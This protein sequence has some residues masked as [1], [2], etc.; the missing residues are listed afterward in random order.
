MNLPSSQIES[1]RRVGKLGARGVWALKYRGGLHVVAADGDAEPLGAGSHR[2]VAR[3]L[4]QQRH[5]DLEWT[6]LSKADHYPLS[7][8]EHLLPEATE[9]TDRLHRL[10]EED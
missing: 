1:K 5:P 3:H 10:W 7:A 2:A 6:E 8:F 4:A 9:L